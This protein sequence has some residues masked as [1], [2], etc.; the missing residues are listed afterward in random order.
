MAIWK[1]V[2]FSLLISLAFSWIKYFKYTINLGQE[3]L[4]YPIWNERDILIGSVIFPFIFDFYL[5]FN[6]I[7]D[8]LNYLVF[9]FVCFF[10]DLNMLVRLRSTVN[11]SIERIKKMS[12]SNDK[13]MEKKKSELEETMK[14]SIRMVILNT[15]I[16]L[17][18][19]F[20]LV[21]LPLVNT[22]AKFYYKRYYGENLFTNLSFDR[23]YSELFDAEFYQVI[24]DSTE[25]LYLISISIQYFIYKKFD[26]KI[27][28]GSFSPLEKNQK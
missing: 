3:E 19:K 20:P 28:E 21:F 24:Y 26:K 4:N 14:K 7:S 6:L 9:V 12:G 2:L 16:G 22:I 27:K 5:V 1:F 15:S 11:E 10:V 23:F 8:F 17:F 25:L 18:F 13:Q